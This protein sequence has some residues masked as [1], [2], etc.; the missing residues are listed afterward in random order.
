MLQFYCFVISKLLFAAVLSKMT[1]YKLCV[2]STG[3]EENYIH[4][5]TYIISVYISHWKLVTWLHPAAREA[6]TYCYLEHVSSWNR[7]ILEEN[8]YWSQLAKSTWDIFYHSPYFIEEEATVIR[9]GIN[10]RIRD[11]NNDLNLAYTSYSSAVSL[12]F[13]WETFLDIGTGHSEW[14]S[15]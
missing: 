6:R 12:L 2:L 7:R 1:W 5:V 15:G 3:R 14:L 8:V 4:I 13:L 10:G 9:K 11:L